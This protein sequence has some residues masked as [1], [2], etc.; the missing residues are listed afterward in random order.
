MLSAR[1]KLVYNYL[2]NTYGFEEFEVDYVKLANELFLSKSYLVATFGVFAN[3]DI[4]HR[5]SRV[6]GG[7]IK[8][9]AKLIEV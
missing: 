3:Y 5:L 7:K 1:Q 8:K 9:F 6:E 2:K 4:L